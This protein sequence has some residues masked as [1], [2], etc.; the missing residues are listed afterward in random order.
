MKKLFTLFIVLIS[1]L[2][3]ANQATAANVTFTVEV[4]TPTYEVWLAGNFNGWNTGLTKMTKVDDTHYTITLDEATF[5]DGVTAAT[6]KYKYLSG[7]GDWA[8][9]EKKADGNEIDDRNYPGA[10]VT[11]KVL[12]WANVYNP[13]VAPIEKNILIEVYVPK[14]VKE[15]YVTGWHNGWKS[16]GSEGTKMTWNEEMSDE[17]GNEFFLTIHT[18]DANK[19][20]YKFAAGPSWV[21][22]QD[23]AD[24][25]ITDTS[26]DN[27]YNFM[28]KFKRIYPG[29]AALKDVTINVTAPAGTET[30][31]MMGSH[32]GW[33]GT[34]W[35][36]GTKNQDG[37]FTFVFKFDLI[38][39][40]YFNQQDWAGEEQTSEGKKVENRKADAQL[41]QTF[42]DIIAK[43]P[44]PAGVNTLDADK[45]TIRVNNKSVSVDGIS[46]TFELYDVTGRAVES[47]TA[48]G[49]HTSKVLNAGIYILRVDG[50]TQKVVIR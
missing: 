18:P 29:D 5:N 20:A 36:A 12:K 10:G 6:L 27:V 11:D 50:A 2:A 23:S 43:W 7:P 8:Y 1:W 42:N 26:K 22:E 4:P 3:F 30:L 25:K 31:Y 16:P 35:Q 24:L 41:A 17:G 46:S 44:V 32:L 40:K 34:S 48:V 37:T 49:S 47:T 13:N 28:P 15:L 21:Y 45:Y 38:E 9:V 33:D 19:T 14:A 39:Y